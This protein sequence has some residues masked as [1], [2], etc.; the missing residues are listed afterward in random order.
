[1]NNSTLWV[2]YLTVLTLAFGTVATTTVW[3]DD[4]TLTTPELL[5]TAGVEA[6]P[7][8]EV[9]S[10]YTIISAD[11]IATYQYHTAIDALRT[12]PGLHVV[13]SGG[14]GQLTSVFTRGANSNQTLVLLNGLAINDP[15]SPGG[16]A[17]LTNIPMENVERI[18]VVR[19]A[20]SALYGSQAIGGVINIITKSGGDTPVSTAKVEVGMLGTINTSATTSGAVK[21]TNYFLSVSRNATEGSDITPANLRGPQ[22]KEKDGNEA[23]GLSGKI[24]IPIGSIAK[25]NLSIEYTSANTDIDDTGYDSFFTPTYENYNNQIKTTRLLIGGDISGRYFEGRYRP[26]LSA[27]LV[28]TLS[29]SYDYTGPNDSIYSYELGYSGDTKSLAFDNAFDVIQ[30]NTLTFGASYQKDSYH[31]TGF[32]DYTGGFVITQGTDAETSTGAIYLGDHITIADSFFLTLSGRYDMPKDFDNRF[33]YTIAPAYEIAATNTR[34]TASYGTGFKA[35]SLYQMFGYDVDSFAGYYAGNPN[36]KPETSKT[37]DIGIE[38]GLLDN[39]LRLG[40]TWFNSDIK[41][42]IVIYYIGF[43]SSAKNADS[44]KTKGLETFISYDIGE[45]IRV[46]IDYTYTQVESPAFTTT[47]TRRPRHKIGITA[48]WAP[49]AGTVLSM[50]TQWV[51]LYRDVPR[52]YNGGPVTYINPAPYTV[53]NVALSQKLTDALTVTAGINNLLNQKYEPANGFEAAGIEALAG[54]AVTF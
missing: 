17:N 6:R 9:A 29:N 51:D 2:R 1:M 33:S 35:P 14:A 34:L 12:V 18:E 46:R 37:W 47:M 38:Q 28:R 42:A 43:N 49:V 11:D 53:V 15:S 4:D 48:D 41:N 26:K 54:I 13:Q 44:L 30:G 20:Q 5:V 16:A 3:A 52:T 10:S 32:R 27:G 25:S 24:G 22:P 23:Y 21:G 8:K 45:N 7:A 39:K 36:L 50:N 19:G 40:A 31:S